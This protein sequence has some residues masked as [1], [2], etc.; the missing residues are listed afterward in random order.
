MSQKKCGVSLS[1]T[2]QHN[3]KASA[4]AVAIA[5]GTRV[6]GRSF[7]ADGNMHNFDATA[8]LPAGAFMS[9]GIALTPDGRICTTTGAVAAGANYQ[10]GIAYRAD[11]AMHVTIAAVSP[12][13][14]S[15]HDGRWTTNGALHIVAN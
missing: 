2:G 12:A 11:G 3:M 6:A 13:S 15:T 8:A 4:A 9:A 10:N 7:D 5:G 1:D 14:V